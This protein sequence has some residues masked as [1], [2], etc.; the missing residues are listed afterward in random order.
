MVFQPIR[1]RIQ[2]RGSGVG[3]IGRGAP[4]R[5]SEG[6]GARDLDGIRS[7]RMYG[8]ESR[9]LWGATASIDASCGGGGWPV[10]RR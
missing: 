1:R 8:F 3:R 10:R 4:A 9:F 2:R 6:S 5:R 7:M